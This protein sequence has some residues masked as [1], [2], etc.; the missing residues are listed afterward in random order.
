MDSCKKLSNS[1]IENRLTGGYYNDIPNMKPFNYSCKGGYYNDLPNMKPFN[2]SCKGGNNTKRSG[3]PGEYH[4]Y[5]RLPEGSF[6]KANYMGP[7]THLVE[8]LKRGDPPRTYTDKVSQ[9]HDIRYSL[10]SSQ[11]DVAKA[12]RK[13]IETL[14]KGKGKDSAFNIQIGLRPIQLK[15]FAESHGL[16]APGRIASFG[17]IK[18]GDKDE[19]IVRDKLKELE[20]EGF[21]FRGGCSTCGINKIIGFGG[22][23]SCMGGEQIINE[24]RDKPEEGLTTHKIRDILN[25]T[26]F[27]KDSSMIYGSYLYSS[28]YFASDIDMRTMIIG[29]CTPEVIFKQTEKI[30]KSIPK[31]MARKRGVY[32]G[33]IKV[34]Y[35][36]R[37]KLDVNDRDFIDNIIRLHNDNL[38]DNKQYNEIIKL[39]KN[40][41]ENST[42]EL[43]EIIRNLYVLRW[44]KDEIKKGVKMMIGNKKITLLDAISQG[45]QIKIDIWASIN[46][47]YIEVSN[48]YDMIIYNKGKVIILNPS[49]PN[50]ND[51]SSSYIDHMKN[52]IRK[53]SSPVFENF[54]KMAKRMWALARTI[55]NEE[56]L[57]TLTPLFQGNVARLNQIKTDIQTLLLILERVP[58]PPYQTIMDQID[59]L[60]VRISYV[61]DI[62][63]DFDIIYELLDGIVNNYKKYSYNFTKKQLNLT[64]DNLNTLVDYL[65]EIIREQTLKYLKINSLYPV[66]QYIFDIPGN[67]SEQK[68]FD[69]VVG[70]KIRGEKKGSGDDN[71]IANILSDEINGGNIKGVIDIFEEIPINDRTLNKI[72]HKIY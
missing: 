27:D 39:H 53:F 54:F 20:S 71:I 29:C 57:R 60:K 1:E 66:P 28:Q 62:D 70:M 11:D 72:L 15:H 35:D 21:G 14:Q 55:K 48:F 41:D 4:A 52:E 56:L 45:T 8:R 34:G 42:D 9:A 58:K 69:R 6:G 31:K 38:L 30:L 10:A 47:R 43:K 24:I 18:P 23:L 12:D 44:S 46:N 65:K 49:S 13:M 50:V 19:K 5:L 64:M 17:D 22:C 36:L 61:D 63:I 37:F 2:Y 59:N 40:S 33:E 67:E 25:L 51:K 3:F 7:G 32:F 26:K 68:F 16:I